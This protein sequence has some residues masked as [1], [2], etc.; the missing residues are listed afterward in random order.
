[1]HLGDLVRW[2]I[3]ED[4]NS[5]SARCAARGPLW[6]EMM[7][8]TNRRRYHDR[9]GPQGSRAGPVVQGKWTMEMAAVHG[10]PVPDKRGAHGELKGRERGRKEV[11][12]YLS[13]LRHS[14]LKDSGQLHSQEADAGR[15]GAALMAPSMRAKVSQ[16]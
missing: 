16:M 12:G 13:Y 15:N 4:D 6:G 3:G 8:H 1:M 14:G 7:W 10:D 11:K 9:A 2:R 5:G